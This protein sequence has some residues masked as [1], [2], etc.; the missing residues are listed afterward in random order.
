M[1]NFPSSSS[2]NGGCHTG[3]QA[4]SQLE[5]EQTERLT[6]R[7]TKEVADADEAGCHTH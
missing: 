4:P 1:A 2:D 6:R 7:E 3:T 5:H